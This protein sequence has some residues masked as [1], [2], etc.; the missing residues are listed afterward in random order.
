MSKIN[1]EYLYIRKQTIKGNVVEDD[2]EALTGMDNKS[3][4]NSLEQNIK[5]FKELLKDDETVNYREVENKQAVFLKCCVIFVKGMINADV[6]DE[7]I[8]QPIME[9]KLDSITYK[10]KLNH[11]TISDILVKKVVNSASLSKKDKFEDLIIQ[12]FYGDTI[13]LIDGSSEAI[14]IETKGW[15][16]RGIE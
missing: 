4:T 2:K 1:C 10:D 7:H 9:V 6:I 15:E 12:L 3:L 14:L 11:N 8:I 5:I 16:K 13:L